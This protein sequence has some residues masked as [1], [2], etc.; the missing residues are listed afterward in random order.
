VKMQPEIFRSCTYKVLSFKPGSAGGGFT[1]TREEAQQLIE[2]EVVEDIRGRRGQKPRPLTPPMEEASA[3]LPSIQ[4]LSKHELKSYSIQRLINSQLDRQ[5]KRSLSAASA[6]PPLC[7]ED[8]ISV[9]IQKDIGM[10][11]PAGGS[12]VPMRIEASGLDTRSGSNGSLTVQTKLGDP[13][14]YLRPKSVVIRSGA[15]VLEGVSSGLA[16]PVQSAGSTASFV[17]ENP[18]S[19]VSQTDSQFQQ[20]QAAARTLQSTSAYSRQLLQQSSISVEEFLR[21]DLMAAAA[22]ALDA[23]AI[24]GAGSYQPTGLM[25]VTGIN[26]YSMGTNGGALTGAALSQLEQLIADQNADLGFLSW[27]TTPT[28]RNKLRSVP[29]FVGAT[30]PC[31]TSDENLDYLMGQSALVSR[32]VPQGLVKGTS[33]DCHAIIGGFFPSM[34]VVF[35]GA[36]AV[37]VDEFTSKKRGMIEI[38]VH[39]MADVVIRRPASFGVIADARNV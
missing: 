12:F 32:S 39:L 25:N 16:L 17:A 38:T 4:A 27:V 11:P 9:A 10:L 3:L 8:E 1:L 29:L 35:F 31:W 21:S 20:L 13:I 14:S 5:R 30:V 15:Q 18:G 23:A 28:M 26:T 33:S 34:T 2:N 22:V 7:L 37:T 19:D 36:A 24:N 6:P